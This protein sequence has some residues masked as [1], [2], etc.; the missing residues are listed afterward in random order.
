MFHPKQ[1]DELTKKLLAT[2][3]ASLQTIETDIQQTFNDILQAAFARMNLV[4][5]N[6]F[7]IQTKVLARTREKLD[8]LQHQMD[9]LL[10]AKKENNKN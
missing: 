8:Q 9:A 10:V 1:L 4:T 5:R 6:E 2:L 3:P 7:D